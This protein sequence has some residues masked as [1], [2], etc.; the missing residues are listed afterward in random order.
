MALPEDHKDVIHFNKYILK[1]LEDSSGA[2]CVAPV[3]GQSDPR[4]EGR[5]IRAQEQDRVCH[6]LQLR[7]TPWGERCT[8]YP[9]VLERLNKKYNVYYLQD[10]VFKHFCFTLAN[11]DVNTEVKPGTCLPRKQGSVKAKP[12]KRSV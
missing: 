8:R 9:E 11:L 1:K 3:Y 7:E 5:S 12:R 6:L 4:D 2:E 10:T